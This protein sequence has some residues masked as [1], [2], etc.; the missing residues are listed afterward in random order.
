MAA[1]DISYELII[2][3]NA[4]KGSEEAWAMLFKA[5]IKPVYSF[6]LQLAVGRDSNAQ[7]ITQQ[8]FITA[9]KKIHTF[10]PR[11]GTFRQWL[12]GI[13]KNSYRKYVTQNPVL[14]SC[15]GEQPSEIPAEQ[16]NAFSENRVVLEALAQLPAHHRTILEDKYFNN[17]SMDQLAK[18]HNVTINAIG[19][20]LSRARE[21]FKHFYQLL[22]KCDM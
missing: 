8:T 11:K 13:A 12:F 22:Q 1:M 19:L 4:K 10:D 20:R 7:D 3:E 15:S 9:A 6:C 5:N 18:D 21:K 14:L 17:K 2:V 16:S